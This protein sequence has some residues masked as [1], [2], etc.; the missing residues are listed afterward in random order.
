MLTCVSA[1]CLTLEVVFGMYEIAGYIVQTSMS[2]SHTHTTYVMCTT[3]YILCTIIIN[4]SCTHSSLMLKDPRFNCKIDLATGYQTKSILCMPVKSQDG[5]VC[6]YRCIYVQG[7][8]LCL[9]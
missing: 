4:V 5:Q 7:G 9:H 1:L 8:M 2:A 3:Y 6:V